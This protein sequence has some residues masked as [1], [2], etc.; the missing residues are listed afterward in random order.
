MNPEAPSDYNPKQHVSNA[1][2][3][4]QP[5]ERTICE[6]KRHP[7]GIFLIYTMTGILLITVAVLAFGVAPQMGENSSQLTKI[8]AVIFLFLTTLSF[9]YSLIATKVYWG[10]TWV[11]TTDSLTQV[12]Q[13]SL[14]NRQSSQLSLGNLEDVS[15]EQNGILPHLFNYGRLKVETAGEHSKFQFIYCPNPNYHAQKILMAREAFE[16]HGGYHSEGGVPAGSPPSSPADH[17]I[18]SN[19]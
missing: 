11:V 19:V 14:F 12:D 4:T 8:G 9:L 16:Q 7:I 1:L 15:A 5:G 13:V 18:N 3:A 17:G 10:N 2:S 6:I